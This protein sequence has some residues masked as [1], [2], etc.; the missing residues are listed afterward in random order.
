MN[1]IKKDAVV[2]F[3]F[4]LKTNEGEIVDSTKDDGP[5]TYLHGRKRISPQLEEQLAGKKAGDEFSFSVKPEDAYGVRDEKLCQ[6]VNKEVFGPNFY[7]LMV[8]MPLEIE[9]PD[10]EIAMAVVMEVKT[11]GAVLDANHPLAGETLNYKV[12]VLSIRKATDEELA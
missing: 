6:F 9:A 11:D 4:T 7:N 2:D 10:G 8:G 12:K 3:E 5:V 1:S